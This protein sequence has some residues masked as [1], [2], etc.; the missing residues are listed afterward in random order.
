VH[1]DRSC[2]YKV[3]DFGINRKHLCSFLLLLSSNLALVT[4]HYFT[5]FDIRRLIG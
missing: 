1:N 2:S 4:W 3:D 5:V